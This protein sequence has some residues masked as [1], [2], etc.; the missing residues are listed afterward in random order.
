MRLPLTRIR[1][2]GG[3]KSRVELDEP[4]IEEYANFMQQGCS[5]PP[6]IVF[7]D[8]DSYWLS[9]G[10]YRLAAAIR[11][12]F[13]EIEVELKLG[14][15][16]D[17]L[18]YAVGANTTHGLKRSPRDKRYA[19]ELL[20]QDDEWGKWSDRAI[21]KATN[22]SHPLVAKI[23]ARVTGNI[24]SERVYLTKHGTPATMNVS[25][26]GSSGSDREKIP[27]LKSQIPNRYDGWL[28]LD[29][30]LATVRWAMLRADTAGNPELVDYGEIRTPA[31]S[32]TAE[33]LW[34]LERDLSALLLQFRPTVVAL[35]I[36]SRHPDFPPHTGTIEAIGVIELI[37]Y[38]QQQIVPLRLSPTMWKSNL[39]D[40]RADADEI[41]ETI[42]L[43]FDL[44][45]SSRLD[46]IGIAY[47]AFCG[48]DT[49]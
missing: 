41:A 14:S 48:V 36:P 8:G 35:E 11:S 38:R 20:L 28:G 21:A 45:T 9:D 13:K 10:F 27:N 7:F 22:T 1:T 5:F 31:R 17:A 46:A 6:I 25:R 23:R 26:I 15:Q 32:P 34:E 3:T 33:R 39:G 30:G 43:I 12:G 18:F 42:A 24:S 49:G 4:T 19:I 37:C 44:S 29:P 16:R 2:D 47:A 40:S